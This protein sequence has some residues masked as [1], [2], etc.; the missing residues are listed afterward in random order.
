MICFK[1][2]VIGNHVTDDVLARI[3]I[4]FDEMSF[5]TPTLMVTKYGFAFDSQFYDLT[6]DMRTSAQTNQSRESYVWFGEPYN[7]V[8]FLLRTPWLE[9]GESL[10]MTG[11]FD[12]DVW[13]INFF[14]DELSIIYD[15]VYSPQGR[16][17]NLPSGLDNLGT[18]NFMTQLAALDARY[19]E[20]LMGHGGVVRDYLWRVLAGEVSVAA[21][22]DSYITNLMFYGLSSYIDFLTTITEAR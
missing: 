21:T 10:F 9:Q 17:L 8:P 3:L 2:W 18:E 1:A 16:T 14:G 11:I 5:N 6:F 7:S 19:H 22:W 20:G 15:F 13:S 12:S 4:I